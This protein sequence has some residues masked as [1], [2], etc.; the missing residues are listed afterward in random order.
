MDENKNEIWKNKGV[1]SGKPNDPSIWQASEELKAGTY[2]L[3]VSKA[4]YNSDNTGAYKLMVIAPHL[5]KLNYKDVKPG[6][7][8]YPGVKW[9]SD[10]GIK[11]YENGKFGAG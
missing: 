4:K 6:S 5:D 9:L 3:K 1:N 2:Y 8:H 10:N 7:S 11:G